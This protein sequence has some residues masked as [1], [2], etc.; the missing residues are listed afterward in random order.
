MPSERGVTAYLDKEDKEL[1]DR[2]AELY[3]IG[4]SKLAKEIIHAWLFS[5]KLHLVKNKM[6]ESKIP[7]I[8]SQSS[9]K[10]TKKK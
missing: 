8:S 4:D 10:R 7:S 9:D 5:N 6:S 1:F 2:A 3:G